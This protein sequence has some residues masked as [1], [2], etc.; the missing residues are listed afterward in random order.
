MS[1]RPWSDQDQRILL[2]TVAGTLAANLATLVIVFGGIAL[3]RVVETCALP[4]SDFS[5]PIC[6]PHDMVPVWPLVWGITAGGAVA[7]A[8]MLRARRLYRRFKPIGTGAAAPPSPPL[9]AL[10][11]GNWAAGR[12]LSDP[13][14]ERVRAAM[15]AVQWAAGLYLLGVAVMWVG[16]ASGLRLG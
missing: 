11:W 16:L 8:L 9:G 3:I 1:R 5:P 13:E 10:L 7:A 12:P 14:A 2:I 4:L 6:S 15:L